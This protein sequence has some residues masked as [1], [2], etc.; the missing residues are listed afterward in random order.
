[1]AIAIQSTESESTTRE[2]FVLA[3]RRFAVAWLLLLAISSVAT[4]LIAFEAFGASLVIAI[5]SGFVSLVAM[6][7]GLM[8]ERRMDE[9]TAETNSLISSIFAAMGIRVTGTVAL[10]LL[11]RYEMGLPQQTIAF[12]V[13]GWYV[14]LTSIEVSLL[15]LSVHSLSVK[16]LTTNTES[17]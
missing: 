10:F 11:C 5:A 16:S 15:V 2:I 7:P 12:F 17:N 3:I 6:L 4:Y 1:M 13:C 8:I 9:K 14:L